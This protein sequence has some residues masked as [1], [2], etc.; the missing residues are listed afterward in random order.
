MYTKVHSVLEKSESQDKLLDILLWQILHPK[1]AVTS[2][3]RPWY[4]LFEAAAE[5]LEDLEPAY[6]YSRQMIL[7]ESNVASIRRPH[8]S[9]LL[10]LSLLKPM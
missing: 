10:Q 3:V 8:T 6:L 5:L 1:V 4:P 2:R 7:L 9:P